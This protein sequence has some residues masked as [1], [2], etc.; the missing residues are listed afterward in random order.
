MGVAAAAVVANLAGAKLV[1]SLRGVQHEAA[2]VEGLEGEGGVG[3]DFREEAGVG[4]AVGVAGLAFHQFAGGR[5]RGRAEFAD[6]DFAEDAEAFVGV[7][8]EAAAGV[9][10]ALAVGGGFHH[11]NAQGVDVAVFIKAD[12][13]A[14]IVMIEGMP[15]PWLVKASRPR[16][17][18]VPPA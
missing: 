2:A 5:G 9:R 14:L 10:A 3:G 6:G 7:V 17:G 4:F 8:V 16:Q 13:A 15:L 18:S 11:E 1:P 12:V